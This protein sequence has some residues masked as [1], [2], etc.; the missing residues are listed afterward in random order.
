M[1][2]PQASVWLP[3]FVVFLPLVDIGCFQEGPLI[4]DSGS[5]CGL[6]RDDG[7]SCLRNA[8]KKLAFM[9]NTAAWLRYGRELQG[10]RLP[11]CGTWRSQEDSRNATPCGDL[12]LALAS[13]GSCHPQK[14][15]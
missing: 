1:T 9:G 13:V 14:Q 7:S 6:D 12:A 2:A 3:E 5:L 10:S 4:R 8:A 15:R 11:V